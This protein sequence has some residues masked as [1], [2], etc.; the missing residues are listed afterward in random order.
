[1]WTLRCQIAVLGL[2]LKL[3][4]NIGDL[5]NGPRAAPPPNV[6]G[7]QK[8]MFTPQ[9]FRWGSSCS[10]CFPSSTA[11]F[12]TD[13]EPSHIDGGPLKPHRRLTK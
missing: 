6:F 10:P 4:R 11:H 12:S 7:E 8:D 13:G 1:M 3:S 5:P 2:S 9:V